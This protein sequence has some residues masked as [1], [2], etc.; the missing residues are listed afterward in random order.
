[1]KAKV[2]FSALILSFGIGMMLNSCTKDETE[3]TDLKSV[4]QDESTVD[5][6]FD[7]ASSQTDMYEDGAKSLELFSTCTPNVTITK[8]ADALFPKHIVIDY[9]TEGCEGMHGHIRKGK[10]IVDQTGFM[11][12]SGSVRTITFEDFYIDDFKIEGT[13][14]VTSN[15]LN[16]NQ[17]YQRTTVLADGKITTPDGKVITRTAEHVQEWIAG[18]GTPFNIFD[19]KWQITG[20]ATGTNRFGNTYNALITTPL[21]FDLSCA[22]KITQG[23]KS[24]T[25]DNHVIIIDFGSGDCDNQ[26]TITIDGVIQN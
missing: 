18:A 13:R 16:E 26:F 11:T 14:T 6:Y 3:S 2:F 10:I 25:T 17:N 22:Y 9:G 8:P 5:N 7:D 23:I 21:I 19:D 12:V 20:S 4:S 24:I 1:M 15:G